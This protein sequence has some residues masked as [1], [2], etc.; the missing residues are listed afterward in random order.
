MKKKLFTGLTIAFTLFAVVFFSS[1]SKNNESTITSGPSSTVAI[2]EYFNYTVNNWISFYNT[3]TDT[4]YANG[5]REASTFG[6]PSFVVGKR[7]PFVPG[8]EIKME[9]EFQGISVGSSQKMVTFNSAQTGYVSTSPFGYGTFPAPILINITE[10]GN[11]G[12]YISGNF[13]GQMIGA[14]PTNT[15]YN[16]TGSFKVKRRI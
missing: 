7:I 2:Q 14:P 1:C 4:V 6:Q 9:Y 10:Y 8:D 15:A 13:S 12:D 3:P 11:V 16:V 5:Q